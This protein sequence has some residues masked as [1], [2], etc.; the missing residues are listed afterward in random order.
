MPQA[1]HDKSGIRVRPTIENYFIGDQYLCQKECIIDNGSRPVL[2]WALSLLDMGNH[3]S[4][5][6]VGCGP[7]QKIANRLGQHENI[8]ITGL[9][10]PEATTLAK[11]FNPRGTYLVCDLDSDI[12]IANASAQ[13]T[14]FDVVFLM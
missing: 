3:L 7:S 8:S 10:S 11:R 12:S 14:K 6:D 4:I 5:L 13:M 9:D 2:D 1:C